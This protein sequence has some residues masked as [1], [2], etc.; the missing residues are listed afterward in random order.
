MSRASWIDKSIKRLIAQ[1][2]LRHPKEPREALY[3]RLKDQ[4]DGK[5]EGTPSQQTVYRLISSARSHLPK[6]EEPWTMASLKDRSLPPES[7]PSVLKVWRYAIN[8][9]E[10][11]TLA[12][13]EW[14]SRLY[15]V[16]EQTSLLW[17]WSYQYAHEERLS[18]VTEQEMDSFLLDSKLILSRWET[19]T[20][21]RTDFRDEPIHYGA[22]RL[23]PID[24]DG[25]V[26]EELLHGDLPTNPRDDSYFNER[27][28]ALSEGIR[29]LLPLRTLGFTEEAEMVYLRW[30][31]YL[32]KGPN[33][34]K[35]PAQDALNIIESLREIIKEE[36]SH[37]RESQQPKP[38]QPRNAFLPML[39]HMDSPSF[40][41]NI[42]PLLQRVG[43][44]HAPKKAK[45]KTPRHK[46]TTQQPSDG[47]QRT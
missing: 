30:Y 18:E 46:N 28:L 21:A 11:F 40:Y 17:F 32:I 39:A 33:W 8:T 3:T 1:E 19:D 15:T 7:I 20:L 2:A 12:Q 37:R 43:Y 45:D 13:A 9:S 31:T 4:I 34:D 38:S 26:I 42:S 44:D 35:L 14:V 47:E 41:S 10:K 23:L 29:D 24:K 5:G 22:E 36:Q 6:F 16:Y 27:N 25:N